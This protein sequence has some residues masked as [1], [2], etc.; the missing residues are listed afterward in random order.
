MNGWTQARRFVEEHEHPP[1]QSPRENHPPAYGK[2]LGELYLTDGVWTIAVRSTALRR[3]G[4]RYVVVT[5]KERPWWF[6]Y[7]Y[8]ARTGKRVRYSGTHPPSTVERNWGLER[9]WNDVA[10]L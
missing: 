4:W 2:L 3:D 10:P 1:N 5:C 9:V 8:N 7:F 6:S